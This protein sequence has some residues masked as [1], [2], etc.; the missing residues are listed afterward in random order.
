VLVY[1]FAFVEQ[2]RVL[3]ESKSRPAIEYHGRTLKHVSWT[4]G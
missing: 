3:L 4:D 1:E 2:E